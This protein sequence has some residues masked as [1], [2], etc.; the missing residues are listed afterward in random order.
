MASSTCLTE[1]FSTPIEDSAEGFITFAY[2]AVRDGNLV[3]GIRIEYKAG[4]VVA[5]SATKNQS[6][7]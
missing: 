1:K 6:F 2:P 4:E 3:E 7:L 5:H